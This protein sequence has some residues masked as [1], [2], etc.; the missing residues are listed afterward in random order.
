MIIYEMHVRD[1]SVNDATVPSEYQGTFMA[2]AEKES[3]GMLHLSALADAGMTHLHLLPTFDIAT[4]DE[5]K[6]NWAGPSFEDLAAFPPDAEDQQALIS[7]IRDQDPFNWGYDPFH[8]NV[9]E[10][11]YST[12]PDGSDRIVEFRQ[13]VQSV[14]EIGLRVVIDVVYNHTNASGQSANSVLDKIV[15][16]YYHRLN[17]NGRVERSTCC[18]NTATEHDMMRKLM[19]DSVVLWAVEY[20][21]DGFRFDLMGHHMKEDMLAVRAAL[22]A[23]TLSKSTVLM[24]KA[25]LYMGKG[26]TL[27]KWPTT[28]EASTR[29]KTIWPVPASAPSTTV[30]GTP[31]V[32]VVRLGGKSS[33]G[34]STAL[35]TN[36][37][38]FDQGPESVQLNRLGGFMDLVRIGLAGNLRD[39]RFVNS[40]GVEVSGIGV[41]YN[42]SAAGYTDDPQENIVYVSKHDNETLVRHH[43]IQSTLP[44]PAQLIAP[45]CRRWAIRL[46]CLVKGFRL[47]KQGMICSALSRLIAI[48]TTRVT[49]L[50][51]LDFTYQTNNF[52]IGLPP[53]ADNQGVWEIMGGILANPDLVPTPDDIAYCT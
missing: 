53:A 50:I 21:V 25:S 15:P 39:Y 42:G 44:K 26:G 31:P 28:P 10:G 16:G 6:S 17:G 14:N 11:S 36:P 52:G 7:E 38:S 12:D 34:L 47:P 48:A 5:D 37:N 8:Y 3:N 41:D 30:C 4:I 33:K 20:K 23:L 22:D 19:I 18:E 13:M 46:F 35:G 2:F 32:A 45:V 1:F 49:G 40:D 27:V 9:P 29:P 24:A 51:G 43:S